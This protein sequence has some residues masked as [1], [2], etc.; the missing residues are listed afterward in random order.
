MIGN[1]SKKSANEIRKS[2]P[3]L[4][5]RWLAITFPEQFAFSINDLNKDE[6]THISLVC[7]YDAFRRTE[8]ALNC[9]FEGYANMIWYRKEKKDIEPKSR[10]F[11]TV[12]KGKFYA[13]YNFLFLY[14]IGEDIADF[15]LNFL[16]KEKEFNKW[17]KQES[18][19]KK[20]D[21][22]KITSKAAKVGV[23]MADQHSSHKITKI[24]LK[25]RDNKFWNDAMKYRNTWVHQ[26]PPIVEGLGIEYNRQ[27]KI[28][29]KDNAKG[30]GLGTWSNPDYKVEEVM[31]IA[32]EATTICI[33]VLSELLEI[34][35]EKKDELGTPTL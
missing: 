30:F 28:W 8:S 7:L 24:I 9:L 25:L 10:E 11:F 15:V 29:V 5:D 26:K 21:K 18:V 1:L 20:L 31:K 2:L 4:P 23:F 27:S 17:Q 19:Q 32:H 12:L 14:A 3:V 13:E 22:K 6:T 16:T 35:K 34:L 33:E